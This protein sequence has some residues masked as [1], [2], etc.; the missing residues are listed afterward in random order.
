MK[1]KKW[2]PYVISVGISL[3][4]GILSG[5]LSMG[6]MMMYDLFAIKPGLT[7]PSWV[8]PVV[9]SVLYVL[10]GISAAIIWLEKDSAE[11]RRGLNLYVAQLIVNF[12]W[13]LIFF[14]AQAYGFAVLWLILLWVLVL[15]MILQFRKVN[16]LAAKLQIPYLI[17]LTF[18]AY[19]NIGV[20]VLNM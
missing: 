17:W 13:S 4:I 3:G 15:L 14:N 19:L 1:W 2:K 18:A 20:W 8:F 7:P 12:F 11:R 6:G 10:M 9:W 5:L 16:E